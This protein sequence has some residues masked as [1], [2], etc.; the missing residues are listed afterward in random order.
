MAQASRERRSCTKKLGIFKH[1]SLF[2]APQVICGMAFACGWL[3]AIRA[4]KNW[5]L[6]KLTPL[7]GARP[8]EANDGMSAIDRQRLRVPPE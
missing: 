3:S 4:F 5:I 6:G 8:Q 7:D 1:H 2:Q